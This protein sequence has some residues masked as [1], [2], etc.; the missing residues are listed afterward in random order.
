MTNQPQTCLHC[1]NDIKGRL[2]KKYCDD[3]CRNAWHNTQNKESAALIRGTNTILK[4]NRKI[5]IDLNITG[6]QKV[7]KEDLLKKGFDFSF[8][9][10]IYKTQKGS[11]YYFCYEQ[12]YL[13]LEND[14]YMLVVDQRT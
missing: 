8:L 9:T 11:T 6:K 7:R 3:V 14:W 2:D 4:K 10:K 12:G 5:L 1:G 13:P